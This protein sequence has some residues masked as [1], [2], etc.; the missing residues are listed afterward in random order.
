[1]NIHEMTT[2]EIILHL[3]TRFHSVIFAGVK[4]DKVKDSDIDEVAMGY[5]GDTRDVMMLIARLAEQVEG[6]LI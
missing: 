5:A 6:D 4:D 1:M 3:E 2:E